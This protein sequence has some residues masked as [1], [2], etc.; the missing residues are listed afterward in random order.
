MYISQLVVLIKRLFILLIVYSLLRVLFLIYN[1]Q[2][3]SQA[4]ITTLLLSF[5]IGLR[6]D[7]SSILLINSVFLGLSLLPFD[8]VLKRNYQIFLK[9]FFLTTNIPFIFL[10]LIDLEFFKF[11]GKRTTFNIVGIAN[12]VKDQSGQVLYNYWHITLIAVILV[13]LLIKFYPSLKKSKSSRIN[14]KVSFLYILI[15]AGLT[16]FTIRG[17]WQRRPLVPSHAFVLQPS[18]LGNLI[19]NSSFSFIGTIGA[20]PIQKVNYFATNKQAIKELN[21]YFFTRQ[22]PVVKDNVVIIILESFGAEYMGLGRSYKGYTPFLDSLAA[23]SYF[24]KNNFANGLSSIDAVPSVLAGIPCL[25]NESYIISKFQTNEMY[26]LG[27]I[28]IKE[29]YTTAFFHGGHNGTMGFDTFT[30]NAGFEHYY[31]KDEYYD[32]GGK[33]EDEDDSWGI[34]DEPFLQF[35]IKRLSEYKEPFGVTIF[36]L[37]SH[38]PYSIPSQYKNKFPKGELAVHETIGYADFALKKFF[39][40][41]KKTSWYKN[42]IFFITADHTQEHFR[43]EYKNIMG[44]FNTPLLIFHPSKSLPLDTSKITQQV[45]ITPTIINYLGIKTDKILPF[46]SSIFN[47]SKGMALTFSDNSYRFIDHDYYIDFNPQGQ[48]AL[49]SYYDWKKE[50]PI[51][52]TVLKANYEKKL[53]AYI[54]FYNNGLVENNW[55]KVLSEHQAP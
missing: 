53:K 41:A 27:S 40:S 33:K 52:D 3:F 26:G 20:S 19:L 18:V 38:Q 43:P 4:P 42:T 51:T 14:L 8:F 23:A 6:F 29:G 30:S 34:F 12:D 37:S 21:S 7:L 28:L 48:S 55:Y 31:G 2:E 13:I 22:F 15:I 47:D 39:E 54:Q 49:Y 16:V 25:A 44:D 1:Y 10:N 9:V 35:T 50:F 46:G 24:F 32:Y 5:L 36:T 11:T 45:D 17:G